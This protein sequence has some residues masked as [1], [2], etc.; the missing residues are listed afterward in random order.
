MYFTVF[1]HKAKCH[2][3]KQE[4]HPFLDHDI[5]ES[6]RK[7]VISTLPVRTIKVK[8]LHGTPPSSTDTKVRCLVI[9]FFPTPLFTYYLPYSHNDDSDPRKKYKLPPNSQ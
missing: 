4:Y 3:E 9:L 8:S 6:E 5:S 1:Y 7:C 2:P